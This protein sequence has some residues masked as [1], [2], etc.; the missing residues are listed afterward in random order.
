MIKLKRVKELCSHFKDKRILVFGDI[1]LDRYI[2]GSVERISPEA[3][4]PVVKV[5]K[6]EFRAGGAGNVASNIEKLGAKGLLMGIT[7][8][9]IYA[10]QLRKLNPYNDIIIKSPALTT[11]VKTRVISGRQQIVRIDREEAIEVTPDLEVMIAGTLDGL[12]AKGLDGII[13]SDYAKGTLNRTIMSLLEEKASSMRIPIMV[14]PKPPNFHLYKN[15]DGITPNQKEAEA[16]FNRK[17]ESDEDAASAVKFIRNKYNSR[18][19]VVTRGSRGISAGEKGKRSFHLPAFNHEVFDVTG[20]GDTV[21]SVLLLSLAV[22][23]TLREAVSLANAAASIV[24]EKIGASQV[25]A[26]EII[27]RMKYLLRNPLN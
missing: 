22:G 23:A 25:S 11:L 20:A 4:V 27:E 14:D 8:N 15:I 18:F 17:I 24:V 16:M 1:I 13:V 9:D 7:G 5:D 6:E 21:V 10:A 26:D 2:F 12:V 19:S 3:P